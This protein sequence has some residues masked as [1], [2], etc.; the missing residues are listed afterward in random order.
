MD[1][2][3]ETGNEYGDTLAGALRTGVAMKC[4]DGCENERSAKQSMCGECWQRIPPAL[5]LE[6]ALPDSD[7][8][9]A[10][11]VKTALDWLA[12]DDKRRG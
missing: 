3:Y 9:R 11:D 1:F 6:I 5:A 2:K 10:H 7:E 4:R 8:Q 12:A